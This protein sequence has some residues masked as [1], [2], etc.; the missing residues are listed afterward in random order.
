MEDWEWSIKHLVTSEVDAALDW[1]EYAV[2]HRQS[3]PA[4]LAAAGCL[5]PLRE[6]ALAQAGEDD[7]LPY[8]QTKSSFSSQRFVGNA[9]PTDRP[10]RWQPI[11][12][13]GVHKQ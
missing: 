2:E 6:P 13:E 1:Y 5:R 7:E 8:M 3:F 9:G 11:L 4:E 12:Q 10:A